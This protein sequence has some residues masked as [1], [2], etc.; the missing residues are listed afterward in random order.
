[1]CTLYGDMGIGLRRSFSF[2]MTSRNGLRDWGSW[3]SKE[4]VLL[5]FLLEIQQNFNIFQ[6]NNIVWVNGSKG[7][8]AR[9]SGKSSIEMLYAFIFEIKKLWNV[10]KKIK[11][12]D[13]YS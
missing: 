11:F 1:M 13:L 5:N 8:M 6:P 7:D 12:A 4:Q 10:F 3:P 9:G 2:R